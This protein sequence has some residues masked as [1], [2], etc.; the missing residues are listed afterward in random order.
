MRNI[1][2]YNENMHYFDKGIHYY[3][4]G[5]H[6]YVRDISKPNFFINIYLVIFIKYL[7]S[8]LLYLIIILF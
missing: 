4:G 2:Y 6:Y 7:Y 3:S 5:M 1:Y 8:N